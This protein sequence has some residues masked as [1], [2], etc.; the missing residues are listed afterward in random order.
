MIKPTGTHD[1]KQARNR[2]NRIALKKTIPSRS[3]KSQTIDGLSL[4]QDKTLKPNEGLRNIYKYNIIDIHLYNRR[5]QS[6]KP[7]RLL[8]KKA[9]PNV[10]SMQHTKKNPKKVNAKHEKQKHMK[11]KHQTK[12]QQQGMAAEHQKQRHVESWHHTKTTKTRQTTNI[13]FSDVL[14]R[15]PASPVKT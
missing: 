5:L 7:T 13:R 9:K 8:L 12:T 6:N 2:I 15:N 11:E 14:G 1:L 3:A 4:R 10:E